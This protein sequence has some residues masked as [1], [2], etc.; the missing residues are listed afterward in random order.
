MP[1]RRK[2]SKP[3]EID[4]DT[5]PPPAVCPLCGEAEITSAGRT[6]SGLYPWRCR[7]CRR[8]GYGTRVIGEPV[9]A[10][11]RAPLRRTRSDKPMSRFVRRPAKNINPE[12][13]P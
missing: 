1:A 6:P 13:V 5:A 3:T 4:P 12:D 7:A 10:V 2:G 9:P 8:I 11:Q